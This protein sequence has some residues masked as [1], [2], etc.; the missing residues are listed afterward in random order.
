MASI[1]TIVCAIDLSDLT[2]SVADYATTMAKA[3]GAKILVVYA[4]PPL[5]QYAALEVQPKAIELFG[6]EVSASVEKQMEKAMGKLFA[7][8]DATP[9]I[10]SGYPAEEIIK[11][12]KG[13][14]ADLIVMGTHGR[15]GV[16]LMI[17]GSV[18]EKVVKSS[19]IPVLTINP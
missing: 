14:K 1:K 9:V 19:K 12:A 7:G 10:A 13:N 5:N 11:T 8:V 2:D 6:G 17:F 3:F 15:K 18:A 16:D 4:T